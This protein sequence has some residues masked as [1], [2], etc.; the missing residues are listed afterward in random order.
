MK[1]LVLI[2]LIG[3]TCLVNAQENTITP[4]RKGEYFNQSP[5]SDSAVIFAPGIFSLPNRL[6]SNIAFTPDGKECYFGVLEI[7]DR[8]VSYKIFQSTFAN[9]KWSEQTEAPFSLNQN[10]GDPVLSADGKKLYFNKEGDIWMIERTSGKWGAPQKLPVP[11]NSEDNEGSITESA[12]G[13]IYISSRRPGGFGGIDIWRINRLADQSLQAENFGPTIN[14][15]YFDYSPF[16]APDGSYLI[17]GSYRARR[18]GLLYISFNEGDDIWTTPINM[19]SCGAKVNNTTAHHSNPSLSPDGKYLF[20]RRHE[21]DTVMDVFWVSAEIIKPL[22]EKALQEY[23]SRKFVNLKGDFLGQTPPGDVPVIF[24]PGIISGNKLEHSAAIFSSD[25]NEVYWVS[26]ENQ[27]SKLDIWFMSRINNQWSQPEIFSPLGDS[28]NLFD[29]FLS[30]DGKKF[31]FGADNNGDADIW[32]VENQGNN[33]S[34]P[35]SIGSA[36]NNINGQCQASFTNNGNAYYLDYRTINNKWTCDIFKSEFKNGEYLKPDTLPQYINSPSQDWTPYV[37]PDDSYLI[38]SSSRESK[39]GDLYI[40]YHDIDNDKWLEPIRLG[41]VINTSKQ[42][43]FPYVSPD[44]K[45]LFFTRFTNKENDMDIYWVSAKI[46]DDLK[47]EVFN[48]MNKQE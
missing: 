43:T 13:D 34:K 40:S 17:F 26:R 6:E 41:D 11:I 48:P 20:F 18:D 35:Q 38:F 22:K 16:I 9:N 32:F 24:A 37:A 19:N 8:N 10:I 39:Y 33:W 31:Y 44:G 29:P 15:M 45:Y 25:G 2:I 42:E 4:V 5:P 36:I 21:T 27:Y 46:I 30:T 28:V 3:L 23:S 14:S 12:D 1:N 47:K 7:K